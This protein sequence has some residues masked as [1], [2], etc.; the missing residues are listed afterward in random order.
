MLTPATL[1]R[2]LFSSVAPSHHYGNQE[3]R[4]STAT[5]LK[6]PTQKQVHDV[7]QEKGGPY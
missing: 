7:P 4:V 3:T 5:K 1:L 6:L 2:F